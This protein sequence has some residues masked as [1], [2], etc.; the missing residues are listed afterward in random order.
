MAASSTTT[1]LIMDED[2]FLS[3]ILAEIVEMSKSSN[4]KGIVALGLHTYT[5]IHTMSANFSPA[6]A[7]RAALPMSVHVCECALVLLHIKTSMVT[8]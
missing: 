8:L 2:V 6:S 1:V 3:M 4:Q 7:V 5:Y